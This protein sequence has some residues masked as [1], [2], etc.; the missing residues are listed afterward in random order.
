[1]TNSWKS[2]RGLTL[3]ELIVVVALGMIIM[4]MA[5]GGAA[6]MLK[7]SR[8]DG[9]LAELASAVRG[10]RELSISNRRN[11]QVTFG[12]TSI[13]ITRV[14]FCSSACT[15]GTY[16]TFTGCSSTCVGSTTLLR[17]ISLEGRNEFRLTSGL[18]D[19]P[20]AFGNSTAT[21]VGSNTPV[22]F[23][24]DGSFINSNGDI[25]NGSLFIGIPGDSLSARAIT[26][27][28]PTGALHLWRWDG[29]AWV[30]A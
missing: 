24:T 7:T 28:G 19:T 13:N 22:M 29:R 3:V 20:D 16:A 27:F 10:A 15:V 4:G 18:P 23:T 1:M 11:I 12:A 8:A 6:A 25:I 30:E 14:E 21:A 9:G 2:Q 17:T 26:I 5:L